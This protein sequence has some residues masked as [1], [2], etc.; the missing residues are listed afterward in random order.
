MRAGKLSLA[1]AKVLEILR[2]TNGG[3]VTE[4]LIVMVLWGST[5]PASARANVLP[6]YISRIRNVAGREVR[7]WRREKSWQLGTEER[8]CRTA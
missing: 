1:P 3:P 6:C 7:Y 2:S 8:Q 5:P 4:D